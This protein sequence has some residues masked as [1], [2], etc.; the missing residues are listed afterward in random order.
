M[1]FT[2]LKKTLLSLLLCLPLLISIIF[3]INDISFTWPG[4]SILFNF[5]LMYL[6]FIPLVWIWTRRKEIIFQVITVFIIIGIIVTFLFGLLFA[7]ISGPTK[8]FE[9]PL[10]NET[11]I[12]VYRSGDQGAL[13]GDDLV[14]C[15]II[16]PLPGLEKDLD[17]A[18]ENSFHS[19][20]QKT[21]VQLNDQ[22]IEIPN[23][24]ILYQLEK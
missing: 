3:I 18:S 15:L 14:A 13:G 24:T 11:Y 7:L 9:Q 20:G 5:S 23:K 6:C 4:V 10:S 17:C 21:F 22:T 1:C 16:K 8:I 12:A 2:Y 19:E